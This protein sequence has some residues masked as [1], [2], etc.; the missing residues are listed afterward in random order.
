MSAATVSGA[1]KRP[2][3]EAVEFFRQKLNVPTAT[4]RDVW[5]G[6][7]DRAF[8]VAGA[9][10]ADLLADL[11]EAVDAAIADGESIGEF[12]KRFDEIVAR[13]GWHGWTGEQSKAGRDWRTRTI[14]RTNAATS[15]AAGRMAQL[16]EGGL[17]Y[18]MYKHSD[19]VLNPRPLHQSWDGMVLPAGHPWFD[20]HAPPNGWGCFTAG[21]MVRCDALLGQRF[22]YSGEMVQI[23][24]AGGHRLAVTPNHPILTGRG[25][26]SA[27]EVETGDQVLAATGDRDP[28][29][30]G[31]VHNPEPPARCEDLFQSLSAHGLRVA[32]I[33]ADDF[34][35]DAAFGECEVQ[36]SGSDRALM[37][38]LESAR[39]KYASEFRLDIGHH[40]SVESSLIPGGPTQTRLVVTD[41][42]LAE[43]A[44]DCRLGDLQALG[45]D[46]LTGEPSPVEREHLGLDG[47]VALVGNLPCSP[48]IL[49]GISGRLDFRPSNAQL[50]GHSSRLDASGDKE[51]ANWVTAAPDLF[52]E[53]FDANPGCVAIDDVVGVRKFYW[54]G[55][56]YDFT[57]ETGLILAEGIVVSNCQCRIVGV[58]RA[59]AKALGGRIVD[60]P[61]DDGIDPKTGAPRGIDEGW[62]YSPG[63]SL[64]A[65]L[66]GLLPQHVDEPPRGTPL[67]RSPRC[68]GDSEFAEGD[69]PGP[70]PTPRQL[71]PALI[72]P[73]GKDGEWYMDQF[74]RQFGATRESPAV[75]IDQVGERLLVS[76]ELFVDRKRSAKA[77]TKIY[78]VFKGERSRYMLLLAETLKRPQ[79]IWMAPEE[80]QSLNSKV[81][82][83]R[84]YLAWWDPP[85]ADHP[86]L[87]VF[88]SVSK[89][90]WTG[91]T[92]FAID[93][94][95]PAALN[96]YLA[97][98]RKAGSLVW[99]E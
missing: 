96:E 27:G 80:I 95:D 90:W 60:V 23:D 67:I 7:H 68:G 77:G 37:D 4:W 29:V 94:D 58:T 21:T 25:W 30:S 51:P 64:G 85:G 61:P 43:D 26:V 5:Q 38:V 98:I 34:H 57:S 86:G 20:T 72:L 8:I 69:C 2:F 76:D 19:S 79:E 33:S 28:L 66:R 56:V 1:L 53:I 47:R 73:D 75:H 93:R 54:S 32:P 81:V 31:V 22:A 41:P 59:T 18:W 6:E 70:I 12:R 78:K 50:L 83:R 88:E 40:P 39:G 14:Y 91:V 46:R 63:A 97:N 71:D 24:T 62:A 36:I 3:A 35:G 74:L 42:V 99:R 16:K 44:T 9:A 82:F 11:R 52:G 48:Q 45:D 89:H 15:Y 17:P 49:G 87:V 84:R 65:K 55:H 10:K 13:R 92:T